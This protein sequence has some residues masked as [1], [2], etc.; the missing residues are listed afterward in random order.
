[1]IKSEFTKTNN[2]QFISDAYMCSNCG[3]CKAICPKDAIKF[4][5]SSIGRMYA[6]VETDKCVECGMCQKVCPSIDYHHKSNSFE[7]AFL[8]NILNVY[9]GNSLDTNI[10]KNAQSGGVTTQ[11]L[12][13]LF[14]N[15]MIDCAVV[16]R[17]EMGELPKVSP[18]LITNK[19]DLMSTQKSCYTPVDLLTALT[20][21]KC[22]KSVAIVGLPCHIAGITNLQRC[23]N[24]FNNISYKLGLIC[25]RTLCSGIMDVFKQHLHTV[26]PNSHNIKIDWRCKYLDKKYCYSHAPVALHDEFGNTFVAPREMRL[27]LKEMF[28]S[29]RCRGCYDK[30]NTHADITLGD[31]WGMSNI[32]WEKG[33]TAIISRTNRGQELIEKANAAGYISLDKRDATEIINGQGIKD[34]KIS[35]HLFSKALNELFP[36]NNIGYLENIL[37]IHESKDLKEKIKVLETFINMENNL[38]SD[39]ITALAFS[40]LNKQRKQKKLINRVLNRIKRSLKTSILYSF[41]S[42]L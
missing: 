6:I 11:L 34:R 24:Q 3:A 4:G 1:M 26:N 12:S 25:D 37:K 9:V 17:M 19:C 31:P 8:G 29:P 23:S 42:K 14:D 16:V 36:T 18:V 32:D 21:T 20:E 27:S 22:Y 28:T 33:A 41:K 40:E 30:L 2:I 38:K 35:V 15:N 10:Y 39:Q 5:F 13:Y 7:D